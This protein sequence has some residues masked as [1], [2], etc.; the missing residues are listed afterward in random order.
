MGC[1]EV[2]AIVQVDSRGQLVL[3]KEVREKFG[4][5]KGGKMAVVVMS[6]NDTPCCISLVPAATL[7]NSVQSVIEPLFSE[8]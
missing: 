1:C 7:S 3:P 8:I 2:D 5:E 6:Q 4:L